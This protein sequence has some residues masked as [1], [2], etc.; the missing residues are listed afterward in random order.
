MPRD[1]LRDTIRRATIEESCLVVNWEDGH[2]SRYHPIWLR[3][4]CECKHCGTSLN[5]VRR[6]RIHHIPEDIQ[7]AEVRF[8][9][10]NV[11]LVWS[12]DSHISSYSARW[13]RQHCNSQEECRLRSHQPQLWDA[14]MQQR[15]PSVDFTLVSHDDKARLSMLKTICDTG[16]C[17][18]YNAPVES[19]RSNEIIELV[20]PQ[21]QTHFGTYKLTNKISVDN[22]GDITDALDPHIDETYRLSG[23]GITIFQVIRPSVVGGDSTLVDG[24]EAVNRLRKQFPEDFE[25]LT[26][27]PI[28]S[29]RLD[30]AA[31]SGQQQ[32]WY[33]SRLP[34]IQLDPD[35][36]VCGVRLNERQIAP[37][38]LPHELVGP[39][40][41]ALRRIFEIVYDPA[42]RL[43]FKLKAGEGL[44]FNNQ[45]VLH[46][47]TKYSTEEPT[48]SV[49]TS[50]VD[51]DDFYSTLRLLQ[52]EVDS[53][54]SQLNYLQGMA[55]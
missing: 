44:L 53:E 24:F 7:P 26:K 49:L 15:V 23:I 17:K 35:Q 33:K 54:S 9:E 46:G 18:I 48:R 47:R 34:V 28:V 14:S 41:H 43:N 12:N 27:I 22:V 25:L 2:N 29:H 13:L 8:S 3:H 30:Q 5:G 52:A 51:L 10:E 50:S 36:K 32:R 6:I 1:Y 39:G 55:G 45:R 38:D 4:Q 40:Y 31:N 20:G 42:L 16:F 37:L 19:S 11:E 21:R